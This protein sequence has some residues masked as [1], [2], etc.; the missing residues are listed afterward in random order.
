MA[1]IKFRFLYLRKNFQ[2]VVTAFVLSLTTLIGIT[3]LIRQQL[4]IYGSYSDAIEHS[5]EVVNKLEVLEQLL[6]DAETGTRGYLLTNDSSFL[7]PYISVNQ[8]IKPAIED[9]RVIIDKSRNRS[10]NNSEQL[11]RLRYINEK[12]IL[13]TSVL[14][15]L[16]VKH[17]DA[18]AGLT[19]MHN[20][21]GLMDSIR[22]N[23]DKMRESELSVLADSRKEKNISK[24]L[25]PAYLSSLLVF[26]VIL[27]LSS[28]G[29]ILKELFTR[30]K[31]QAE[32]ER[33]ISEVN[34]SNEELE[35]IAYVSSHHLQEPLRKLRLFSSKL[36]HKYKS[37]V[38]ADVKMSVERIDAS[39][40]SMQQL[41]QNLADYTSLVKQDDEISIVSLN[42]VLYHVLYALQNEFKRN[43][44]EI[45][46]DE[47]P[48]VRGSFHRLILLFTNLIE[49][50][51]HYAKQN[52]P[53]N[54]NITYRRG[55]YPHSDK[56]D[57]Q[58]YHI[59]SVQDNG[60]GFD[61]VYVEKIFELFKKLHTQQSTF[62]GKGIGLTICKRIMT[63]HNGFITAFGKV[64]EGA[65]FK[66]Y[67]PVS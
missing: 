30:Y 44:V 46:S 43:K 48:E 64:N 51:L 52:E 20:E 35:Q 67:F 63:N 19:L 23:F 2:F 45:R 13:Q 57:K 29:Y 34:Q 53:L 58:E 15:D 60:I 56:D 39:A 6:K 5:F 55:L 49:N 47:L 11:D 40:I 9:L 66:L 10:H 12:I 28:F 37:S 38:E 42:L 22:L 4:H 14:N 3:L 59:I 41:I 62:E 18:A 17:N 24:Q 1:R 36:L 8:L 16:L 27:T 31:Y 61:N 26:S 21:K 65:T 33:K 7:Q 54:I 32:L 25:T 50:S